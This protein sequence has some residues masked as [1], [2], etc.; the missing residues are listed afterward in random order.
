MNKNLQNVSFS[1]QQTIN[2]SQSVTK[3]QNGKEK[4]RKKKNPTCIRKLHGMNGVQKKYS[5]PFSNGKQNILIPKSSK[6]KKTKTWLGHF[7]PQS[8]LQQKSYQRP[9]GCFFCT[10]KNGAISS[11]P[12]SKRETTLLVAKLAHKPESHRQCSITSCECVTFL[13]F[14]L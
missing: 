4:K 3:A 12:R 13:W 6:C 9:S 10:C 8:G 11:T 7:Q 1:T 5:L 14:N 2:L